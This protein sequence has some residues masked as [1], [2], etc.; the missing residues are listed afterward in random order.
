MYSVSEDAKKKVYETF[1]RNEEMVEDDVHII[2]TWIKTQPH[3]PELM[4]K[5]SSRYSQLKH[6]AFRGRQN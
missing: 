3:L 1:G 2:K 5:V 4:G 6:F